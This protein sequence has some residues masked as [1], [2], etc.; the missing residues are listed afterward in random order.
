MQRPA[1]IFLT[2]F[3]LWHVIA[4]TAYALPSTEWLARDFRLNLHAA[5]RPYVLLLGQ[6]QTWNMF[7]PDP[8]RVFPRYIIEARDAGGLW[9][10]AARIDPARYPSYERSSMVK[11]TGDLFLSKSAPTVAI[12]ERF[13]QQRCATLGL[14][15]GTAVRLHVQT[16]LLP[17]D[18]SALTDAHFEDERIVTTICLRS[19]ENLLP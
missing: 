4:V 13:L 17:E 10:P 9:R 1:R 14:R 8:T 18:G 6:W 5:T 16:A 15:P 11:L 2:A 19:P 12:V 3:L 7:S